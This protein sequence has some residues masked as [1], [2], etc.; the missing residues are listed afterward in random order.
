MRA[1]D[2]HVV[3]TAVGDL[4]SCRHALRLIIVV[5]H[6]FIIHFMKMQRHVEVFVAL[7]G[8][9]MGMGVLGEAHS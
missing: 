5:G 6:G 2:A 1:A 7:M 3:G 8:G 9:R 4:P